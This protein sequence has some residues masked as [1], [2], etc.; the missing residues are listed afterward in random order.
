MTD[1]FELSTAEATARA[2]AALDNAPTRP[3]PSLAGRRS[4]CCGEPIPSQWTLA[5]FEYRG[6]GSRAA[7][8]HCKH[9]GYYEAAHSIDVAPRHC[10]RFEP[11]GAYDYD[12]HYCG[13]RGWD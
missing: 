2:L 4:K 11:H 6:E 7:L 3:R 1:P 13:C 8:L 9:C 12:I 5:F 10:G